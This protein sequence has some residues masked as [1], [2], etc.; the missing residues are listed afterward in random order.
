M[1][2]AHPSIFD[3]PCFGVRPRI[4]VALGVM[5]QL[6][7]RE[8]W[9]AGVGEWRFE[10]GRLR[11]DHRHLVQETLGQPETVDLADHRC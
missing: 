6:E 3:H 1:A 8:Y 2:L 9:M 4:V 7:R 5:D 10:A 11:K